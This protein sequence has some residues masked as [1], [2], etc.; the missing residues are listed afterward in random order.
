[1][2]FYSKMK[3]YLSQEKFFGRRL[4]WRGTLIIVKYGKHFS[5]CFYIGLGIHVLLM[6]M[7]NSVYNCEDGD[8]NE[9][10][11]WRVRRLGTKN[12]Y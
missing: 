12:H 4:L 9:K 10:R 5:I 6:G 1:M 8:S 2:D 11:Q 7:R 3:L